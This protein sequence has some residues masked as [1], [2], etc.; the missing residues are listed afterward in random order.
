[1]HNEVNLPLNTSQFNP[2]DAVVLYSPKIGDISKRWLFLVQLTAKGISVP[3]LLRIEFYKEYV[4]EILLRPNRKLH[5][6]GD[7]AI[8]TTRFSSKAL[9][10]LKSC[11]SR[12]CSDVRGQRKVNLLLRRVP[13]EL[14]S[15]C[16]RSSRP[17][18]APKYIHNINIIRGLNRRVLLLTV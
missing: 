11:V 12:K 16:Q 3:R 13:M 8:L 10:L 7:C 14:Q 2:V 18:I 4:Y 5:I 17:V 9:L 6:Q 1:M 15:H